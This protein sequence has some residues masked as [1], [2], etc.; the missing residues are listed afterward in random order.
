MLSPVSL[1]VRYGHVTNSSTGCTMQYVCLL[2]LA[3]QATPAGT[4][5]NT[6]TLLLWVGQEIKPPSFIGSCLK[7]T[8]RNMAWHRASL[9]LLSLALNF[10]FSLLREKEHLLCSRHCVLGLLVIQVT[11]KTM[12]TI[13]VLLFFPTHFLEE[14]WTLLGTG[15]SEAD[16]G[17]SHRDFCVL[18]TAPTVV[19]Y[20]VNIIF[21]SKVGSFWMI[22][23]NINWPN[24]KF[25]VVSIFFPY[26]IRCKGKKF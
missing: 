5:L 7:L 9:L 11:L 10:Y 25:K 20:T 3:K 13:H 16:N 15:E 6:H 14:C 18:V 4:F 17:S 24:I 19:C 8:G 12:A 26:S 22:T 23:L 1:A 2:G 21:I